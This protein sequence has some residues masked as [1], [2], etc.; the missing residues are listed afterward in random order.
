MNWISKIIDSLGV[1]AIVETV[2]ALM[3][4]PVVVFWQ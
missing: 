3:R 2:S 4:A 1:V